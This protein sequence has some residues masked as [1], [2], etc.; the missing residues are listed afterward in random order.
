M[1]E[2]GYDVLAV[3]IMRRDRGAEDGGKRDEE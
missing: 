3:G 1:L 2:A